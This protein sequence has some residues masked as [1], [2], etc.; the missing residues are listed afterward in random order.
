[1][2]NRK[3][4]NL[5]LES[6]LSSGEPV[7]RL[8]ISGRIQSRLIRAYRPQGTRVQTVIRFNI[9]PV[10]RYFGGGTMPLHHEVPKWL[11]GRRITW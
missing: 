4:S 1:M 3:R 6:D 9:V 2:W 7:F 5:L 8:V 11:H 10:R